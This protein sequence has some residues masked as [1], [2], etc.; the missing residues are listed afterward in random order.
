[1]IAPAISPPI[2]GTTKPT[3]QRQLS[4]AFNQPGCA[5]AGKNFVNETCADPICNRANRAGKADDAGPD[6]GDLKFARPDPFLKPDPEFQ[7]TQR[8][9]IQAARLPA[10]VSGVHY[11]SLRLS[12]RTSRNIVALHLVSYATLIR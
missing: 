3:P 7:T 5:A 10:C 4:K 6:Q 8:L 12:D 9:E 1:M 11:Y 2:A